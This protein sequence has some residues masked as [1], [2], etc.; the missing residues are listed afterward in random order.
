MSIVQEN[1]GLAFVKGGLFKKHGVDLPKPNFEV[2]VR[3]KE[4]WYEITRGVTTM[5]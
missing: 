3:N 5:E 4:P 1:S 2:Y